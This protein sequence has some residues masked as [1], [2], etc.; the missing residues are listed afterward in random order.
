MGHIPQIIRRTGP[1]KSKCGIMLKNL[2]PYQQRIL[3]ENELL[4]EDFKTDDAFV[5]ILFKIADMEQS[6]TY[7]HKLYYNP[8]T[9]T[10]TTYEEVLEQSQWHEWSCAICNHDIQAKMAEFDIGNFV[11]VHCKDAHNSDN[12]RIDPRIVDSSFEFHK[13][14]RDLLIKEQK[15]FLQFIK[16]FEKGHK[17]DYR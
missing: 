7:K 2:K 9:E 13:F 5:G 1:W 3:L 10:V 16:Y 8:Y 15:R 11:C 6:H 4:K 14:C 12:G 17:R